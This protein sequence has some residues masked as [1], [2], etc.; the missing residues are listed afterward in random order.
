MISSNE[1]RIG[2]IVNKLIMGYK[3]DP[4]AVQRNI[5]IN[6]EDLRHQ[7]FDGVPITDEWLNK[8]G[9]EQEMG[10]MFIEYRHGEEEG[11]KLAS[12]ADYETWLYF[13]PEGGLKLNIQY[14]HQLQNLYF[15][16]TGEELTIKNHENS[17]T[18]N[19]T[20]TS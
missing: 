6:A 20:T 12:R 1:L 4:V 13:Y 18:S 3:K 19:S 15:A 7:Y 10:Q 2:N 11:F 14:V 17:T 8:F 5:T 16:L 9:F